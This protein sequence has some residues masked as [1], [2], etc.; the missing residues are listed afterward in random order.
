MERETV[1]DEWTGHEVNHHKVKSS[2]RTGKKRKLDVKIGDTFDCHLVLNAIQAV[3]RLKQREALALKRFREETEK[4]SP[5]ISDM[6]VYRG[7]HSQE[8]RPK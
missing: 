4:A 3:D 1:V 5:P 6:E 2:C 8:T 7:G